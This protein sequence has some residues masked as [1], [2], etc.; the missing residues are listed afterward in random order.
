MTPSTITVAIPTIP[1]RS[2][3][4]ARAVLS[5]IRQDRPIDAVSIAVDHNH[6]GAWATRNRAAAA[7]ST[8]WTAFLD[9]DDELMP[10]HTAVLLDAAAE[11]QADIVWGWFRVV[12][13]HDPF[14]WGQGKQYDPDSPDHHIV[15]I[16]YVVRT[17]L[18]HQ[19]MA[20]I[21]GFGADDEQTG[22]W[23]VQDK[24]L[25]DLMCRLGKAHAI[26]EPTWRWHH[27]ATNTS[28][29]P[30]RWRS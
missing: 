27:H 25:F 6:D 4:L 2:M 7:V 30:T 3:M 23:Q 15:P 12:G 21:G 10:H 19:A 11:H 14:P 24:P 8:E 17:E 1:P 29:L 28:G 5:A 20:E 18:L 13:G 22:A 16:T 9:D 26:A